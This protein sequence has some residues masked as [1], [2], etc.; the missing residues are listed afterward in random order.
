MDEYNVEFNQAM[1]NLR[2][3]ITDE[4][5]KIER[6]R[7]GLQPDLRE[8]C[9]TDPMGQRWATLNA[10]GEYATLQWPAI[11]A[12]L[13]FLHPSWSHLNALSRWLDRRRPCAAISASRRCSSSASLRARSSCCL[14][15]N[16]WAL[17]CSPPALPQSSPPPPISPA[18]PSPAGRT[19]GKGKGTAGAQTAND[20]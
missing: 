7:A 13:Y 6:Y 10:I 18:L 15:A 8:M 16:A 3:E 19:A 12:R 14:S 17:T 4:A 11:E 1:V 9:R 2:A 20:A 5:V